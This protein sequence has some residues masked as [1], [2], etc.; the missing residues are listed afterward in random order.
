MDN[1]ALAVENLRKYLQIPTSHPNINYKP[2]IEFLRQLAQDLHLSISVFEYVPDNPI[3][4]LTWVGTEPSLPSILLNSH[5]DTV[6]VNKVSGNNVN[7]V[8]K[9]R[10]F[11][12]NWKYDPF[13]AV[14]DEWGNIYG[15]GSQDC[16]S[17]GLMYLEAIRR[18]KQKGVQL[19]RTVHALFVPDEEVGGDRGMNAFVEKNDF[20]ALNI[21]FGIDEAMANPDN[22]FTISYSDR[23]SWKFVI[24]C[25]G[26]SKSSA[27]LLTN[28]AGEKVA[29]ILDKVYKLRSE[30]KLKLKQ[31]PNLT[32]SDVT[33]I[34]LTQIRG[35]QK[36]NVTPEL[37]EMSFDCRLPPPTDLEKMEATIRLWCN[38][39]GDGVSLEFLIKDL[40]YTTQLN[41]TNKY[42]EVPYET[43]V[44]PATTDARYL[45]KVGIPC[46]GFV[47]FRNTTPLKH[48]DNE[49]LN[50]SAYLDGIEF[51]TKIIPALG[52]V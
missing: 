22:K 4:V 45:R 50:K 40:P 37:I 30:Q 15:R 46:I 21:G 13:E 47:P 17:V 51:Y 12:Q 3:A 26:T 35:G 33:S 24:R 9:N 38:E 19:R 32:L 23:L 14:I 36:Y 1:D 25:K 34:N 7:N 29:Y 42:W 11:Q 18:L 48:A 2:V 52:N 6:P 49:Y 20:R 39:A 41:E 5:M 8:I 43:V 28:T 27:L 16:K 44:Y 31:N 10:Y